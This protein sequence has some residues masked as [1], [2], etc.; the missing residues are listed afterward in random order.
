MDNDN[1]EKWKDK[2]KM[3]LHN[4]NEQEVVSR[5]K[6]DRRDFDQ[7]A[8]MAS[9]LGL[10]RY[11]SF[12]LLV[13]AFLYVSACSVTS[14]V[15]FLPV[16]F[17]TNLQSSVKFLWLTIDMIWTISVHRGRYGINTYPFPHCFLV[18]TVKWKSLPLILLT[19]LLV[20]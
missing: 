12:V 17:T 4:Q 11:P 9:Q 7:I 8:A 10:Y 14:T 5:E 18:Y 6:K 3:L 19:F 20:Q 13:I 1:I 2:L 15:F 16:N